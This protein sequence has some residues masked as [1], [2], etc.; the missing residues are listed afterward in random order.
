MTAIPVKCYPPV[1]NPDVDLT[2]TKTKLK[3][4][5]WDLKSR[6]GRFR[7]RPK[8]DVS[9]NE[10]VV[11]EVEF[12]VSAEGRRKVILNTYSGVKAEIVEDISR[13]EALART[14]EVAG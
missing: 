14:R 13:V 6:G 11:K 8:A 2:V 7:L 9:V 10:L 4:I 3:E 1:N 5:I 12:W